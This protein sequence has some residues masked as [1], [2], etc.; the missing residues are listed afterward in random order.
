MNHGSQTRIRGGGAQGLLEQG[1]GFRRP[2]EL[3]GEQERLR[4]TRCRQVVPEQTR[5][6]RPATHTIAGVEPSTSRDEDPAMTA[7]EVP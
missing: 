1:I 3:R 6:K 5:H 7:V 2:L 4:P